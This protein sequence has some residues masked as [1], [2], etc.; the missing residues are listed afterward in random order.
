VKKI[1]LCLLLGVAACTSTPVTPPVSPCASLMTTN[2]IGGEGPKPIFSQ[3]RRGLGA[4]K[5]VQLMVQ[6]PMLIGGKAADPSEWP[7]SV[8][9]RAGNAACSATLVGDRTL[10]MASHC[11]D[12]GGNV[13]FSAGA[14]QYTARC[15][16]HPEYRGNSTADWA[17]CLVDRPVTGVP[18]EVL[19]VDKSVKVNDPLLLS[20]YGCIKPGGGGG[21]DGIF[22]IGNASV[23]AIPYSTTYDIVTKGGAAL[24]FGDSGGSAYLLMESGKRFIIGVNSRGDIATMSYLPAVYSQTFVNWA[25]N[26]ARSNANVRICGV[27]D[28]ALGCRH[29]DPAPQPDGKFEINGKAAC[30]KGAVAPEF[31]QQKESVIRAIREAIDIFQ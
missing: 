11:M 26:W 28:D 24:C 8:Y 18:F 2:C 17:L 12:D 9:A 7:A 25:K 22:R 15:S 23:R 10:F 21:N 4:D 29:G 13:S 30:V 6:S 20:G 3:Y 19:G 1:A 5:T 16:H 14:N 31:L 27:H